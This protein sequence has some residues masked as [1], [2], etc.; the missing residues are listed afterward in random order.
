MATISEQQTTEMG[1]PPP[2]ITQQELQEY[3]ALAGLR[4][5][6]EF[7]RLS[8]LERLEQGAGVESG[9]LALSVEIEERRRWS[10]HSITAVLGDEERARLWQQLPPTPTRFLIVEDSEG[11]HI[12]GGGYPREKDALRVLFIPR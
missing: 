3:V 2:M 4:W 8:I 5:R 6:S 10:H 1:D 11:K 9:D 7:L 12:F